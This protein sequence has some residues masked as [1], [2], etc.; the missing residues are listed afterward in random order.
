MLPAADR[1][2]S[3]HAHFSIAAFDEL[4]NIPVETVFEHYFTDSALYRDFVAAMKMT[5]NSVLPLLSLGR[6]LKHI[7]LLYSA[8]IWPGFH[9]HS[10]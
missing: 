2:C 6:F 4:L 10:R 1:L 3:D 8:I 9:F 5:G 7:S